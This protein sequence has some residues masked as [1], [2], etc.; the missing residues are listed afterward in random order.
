MALVATGA[1]AAG[2]VQQPPRYV[3]R[4]DV[5]RV[6]ID[7]RVLDDDGAPVVRLTPDDFKVRI[8][9]KAARVDSVAWI[10]NES[11]GPVDSAPSD[12]AADPV[13]PRAGRL[14]IFL[15][16]KSLDSSRIVGLMRML[17]ESRGLLA[18]LTADDRVAILSFDSHLKIWTDFTNDRARLEPILERGVLLERPRPLAASHGASLLDR[19]D[20]D[21][22]RRTY[23]IEKALRAIA[24]ALEPLGRNGVSMEGDY[25]PARRALVAARASVFSLDVTDADYHSLA[26]GLQLISEQTGGFYAQ[27]HLFP[28]LAMRDLAG[29]LA[30]YY[31]LFVE[32]PQTRRT[33]HDVDVQLTHRKGTVLARTTYEGG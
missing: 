27:T 31:V 13:V 3:E 24:E 21:H 2:S 7:V 6:L 4:V 9:G 17:K 22:A 26:A 33:T 29:S 10:G 8:D 5:A 30:G 1:A 23:S 18:T 32:K 25:E 19:L 11:P 20:R 14:I 12:G 16:Q 15:F 28:K